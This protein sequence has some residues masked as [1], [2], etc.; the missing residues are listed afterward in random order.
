M[1]MQN[2]GVTN[3]E[4]YGM[5]RFFWTGQLEPC[6]C[7]KLQLEYLQHTLYTVL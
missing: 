3:E 1:F 2:F 4:Y 6:F 5:L 7:F